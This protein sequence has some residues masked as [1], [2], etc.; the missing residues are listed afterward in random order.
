MIAI[1]AERPDTDAVRQLIAA[2]DAFSASLSPAE[3]R[4]PADVAR[5]AAALALYSAHG[6]A[7]CGPF[8]PYA[9]G[10]PSVFMEKRLPGG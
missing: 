8:P 5:L 4:H 9:A 6:Y 1:T 2:S 3:G 7:P 10:P